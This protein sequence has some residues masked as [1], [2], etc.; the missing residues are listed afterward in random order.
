M[1]DRLINILE[2]CETPITGK[3][4]ACCLLTT[5]GEILEGYNTET[6]ERIIHA[7]ERAKSSIHPESGP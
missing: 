1:R 2:E 5:K 3:E 6:K 4:I 7:E